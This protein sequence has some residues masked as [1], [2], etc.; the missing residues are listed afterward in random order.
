MLEKIFSLDAARCLLSRP[1]ACIAAVFFACLV[2]VAAAAPV[3]ITPKLPPA[4]RGAP[5]SA[6]L[7]IASAQ[8]L[9]SVSVNGLPAGII[10]G[11]DG[12][13]GISF[14]GTTALVGDFPVTI[15]VTDQSGASLNATVTLSVIPLAANVTGVSAGGRHTCIVLDGGVQCWGVNSEGE[16]GINGNTP[17]PTPVSPIAPGS[18]ATMVTAGNSH[19]CAVV[20]GGVQCWGWNNN[21]QLG[22]NSVQVSRTP[23]EVFAAGSNATFVAAG[24]SHTCAVIAGGLSCW[25]ANNLG[26]LGI[27]ST[28]QSLVPVQVYPAGSNITAV[29]AGYEHTC[30]IVSGGVRCWGRGESGQIGNGQFTFALSPEQ[31]IAAGS[32]VTAISSSGQHT[33][34]VVAGGVQCWGSNTYGQLGN[35]VNTGVP[36]VAISAGNGATA[37]AGGLDSTCAVVAGGLQCWGS[38]VYGKLGIDSFATQYTPFQVLPAASGVTAVATGYD[39][40]CAIVMG[41][42]KCA[43]RNVYGAIGN[44]NLES[45]R[46]LVQALPGIAAAT[47]VGAGFRMSSCAVAGGGVFCWGNNDSQ[48]L[49]AGAGAAPRSVPPVRIINAGSGATAVAVGG[50]HA[51]ALI[52]G[53]VRC[54]G[55]NYYGQLG[56]TTLVNGFAQPFPS[57]SNVTAVST[58]VSHTC[59]VVAGGLQCWGTNFYGELGDGTKIARPQPVQI[60]PP[61]S[62]VTAVAAGSSHTCA[63]I[64]GGVQCWGANTTGQLGNGFTLE[65]IVPVEAIPPGS[66]ATAIAV[67]VFH[68]CAVV[69]GGVKC[70]GSNVSG[71]TGSGLNGSI[72]YEL[73][74]VQAMPAGSGATAIATG[75]IHSCALVAGGVK[76]WGSNY[77]GLL[78]LSTNNDRSYVPLDTIAPGSGISAIAAG[79]DNTCVVAGTGVACWGAN[80]YGQLADRDTA[81]PWTLVNAL[82]YAAAPKLMGV[83][84]RK[85]HGTA[86]AFDIPIRLGLPLNGPLSVEPRSGATGHTLVLTFDGPVTQ[87]GG[88][89]ARD[90]L[91]NDVGTLQTVPDGNDVVL[92]MTGV[93]DAR[94]INIQIPQVNGSPSPAAVTLGFLVGDVDGSRVIDAQDVRRLRPRT[95]AA[96][97]SNS[98]LY[99]INLSGRINAADLMVVRIQAIRG[100]ILP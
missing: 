37:V 31:A 36:V 62:A 29:T 75:Q 11:H 56:S 3:L 1:G 76:C 38:N 77:A 49:A 42:V 52:A 68:S 66:G 6:G 5:Y 74:P 59:A 79:V 67:N 50:N 57:G 44:G 30:I 12:G 20:R 26:Q 80:S 4:F 27:G 58:G 17:V 47:A 34:A 78:G 16:L 90:F 82:V 60:F 64:N 22:N 72:Y 45:S 33:C 15:A 86:G 51:C 7:L 85:T 84:S 55:D 23:V 89:V 32:Q 9:V 81:G 95:G 35:F 39:H 88:A 83:V 92:T 100:L 13:G 43:G 65:A 54:W 41:A 48:L 40:T 96:V 61:G 10:G 70:W 25:G 24:A 21:G 98:F 73:S 8:P 94:R 28:T 87:A 53:G 14:S 91:G 99:D 63:V 2:Q 71:E 93:P 97:D 18:G 19:T 46:V 69:N